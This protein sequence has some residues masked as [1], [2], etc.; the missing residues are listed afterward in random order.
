M[1][2]VAAGIAPLA[3][4]QDGGG[5]IRRPASHT[6]LVGLKPSLQRRAARACAAE[7][8][9]GFRGHRPAGAHGGGCAPA[10]R[11]DA[12]ARA[13]IA[14]VTAAS[15][16][17]AVGIHGGAPD[18]AASPGCAAAHP[19]RRA[20]R[21]AR[22]WIPQIA[23]SVGAGRAATRGARPPGRA[24]LAAAG[25]GLLMREAW[26]QIGQIGLARCSNSI[27]TG[28]RGLAE[29]PRHGRE[30]AARLPG[31]APVAILEQ[32]RQ[33]R[34]DTVNAVP[35]TSTSIVMP[36]A[37]ALPWKAQE[38][39]PTHIDGQEVGPRGHAVYT[40]WVNAAGLPGAGAAV[41]AVAAKACPSACN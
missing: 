13:W 24:G 27:P 41:R 29:I 40:G 9:A 38:A 35:A 12:R 33:L 7:P 34:R 32:V 26:P 39:F 11:R 23:A 18:D 20:F 1:A 14:V 3:I 30:T 22:R 4:G 8:A 19:L 25:P 28:Q 31:S 37:A 36:S 5:S 2:A 21:R 10:V 15:L 6:G 17:P 16:L